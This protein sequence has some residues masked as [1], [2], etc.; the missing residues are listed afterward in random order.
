M[1]ADTAV[2]TLNFIGE[3]IAIGGVLLGLVEALLRQRGR[4]LL[5]FF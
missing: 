4:K 1:N 2:I 3:C 5:P